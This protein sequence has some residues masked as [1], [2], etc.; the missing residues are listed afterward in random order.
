MAT[1][2]NHLVSHVWSVKDALSYPFFM[3]WH[4]NHYS[5]GIPHE[6]GSG[7]FV[8]AYADTSIIKTKLLP[9]IVSD[10][11][12]IEIVGTTLRDYEAVIE[13]MVSQE[14][15]VACSSAPGETGLCR[16]KALCD[17]GRKDLLSFPVL[18]SVRISKW[19]R[20]AAR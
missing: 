3:Y 11:S 14:K 10:I 6:L 5:K 2:Q 8:L 4:S 16:P 13:A 12:E 17:T 9:V 19:T 7:R 1:P 20:T 18:C 15:L